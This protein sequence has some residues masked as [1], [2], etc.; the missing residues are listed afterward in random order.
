MSIV[1]NFTGSLMIDKEDLNICDSS[2]TKVD[3]SN[4]TEQEVSKMLNSGEYV[5]NSIADSI[6]KSE[7]Y[8]FESI[9]TEVV[10]Y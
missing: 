2:L 4:M 1:V 6:D 9:E 5:I 10:E 7:D 8:S 3:T